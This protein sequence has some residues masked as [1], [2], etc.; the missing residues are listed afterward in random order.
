MGCN[1]YNIREYLDKFW[2][3]K[4]TIE[5]DK[6]I[7]DFFEYNSYP[8][9]LNSDAAY[10]L[11]L[12]DFQENAL[13]GDDFDEAI[14]TQITETSNTST[15]TISLRSPWVWA[16]ASVILLIGI[17]FFTQDKTPTQANNKRH[18]KPAIELVKQIEIPAEIKNNKTYKKTK[19]T[20]LMIS[21]KFSI[22]AKHVEKLNKLKEYEKNNQK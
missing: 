5:E 20:F 6:S 14:L 3:G 18:E 21:G 15:K 13:L 1:Q 22:V 16:A 2:Q 12:N 10:F 11:S 9:E 19:N 8:A 17:T 7:R 4:T